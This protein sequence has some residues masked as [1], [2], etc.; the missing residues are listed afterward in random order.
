M[1]DTQKRILLTGCAGFIG[2]HLCEQLL[3]AGHQVWGIDN[4]DDFYPRVVK[5]RNMSG[6]AAHA[7]FQLIEGDIA[8]PD[9]WNTLNIKVDLVIHLAAKAGVL[10]SLKNPSGYLETNIHGTQRL[11][12]WMR[13]NDCKKL[14]FGSSSSV[15]G[16]TKETPFH[17]A[18]DVSRPISNYAFTKVASEILVRT[19]HEIHGLDAVNL[20]FFTVIGERQRPDLAVN[21]FVRMINADEPVTMYGDGSSARDYT[22]V[23]DIVDGIRKASTWILSQD[24][25]FETINLGNHSPVNLLNMIHTVYRVMGKEPNIMQLPMQKGDVDITYADIS[26]AQILLGYAPATSFEEGVR[27]FI[28]WQQML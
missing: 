23:G 17:E 6:F 8:T 22:Y 3:A 18:M 11:L 16:N 14:V 26:K 28:E 4:F 7:N 5:E 20:R 25:C 9:V 24:Q 2:S 1:E 13:E 21:K 19:Y 27:K 10:P 15:Y 12:E